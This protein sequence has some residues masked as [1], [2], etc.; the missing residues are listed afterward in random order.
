MTNP[1]NPVPLSPQPTVERVI[2]ALAPGDLNDLCDATDAAI[3]MG[4]GFGWVKLPARDVLERYWQ[5][6]VAMPARILVVARLDHV[7]CGAVQMVK[8]PANN[9]A[10]RF[11]LH[12]SGLF[13]APWARGQ[14][15]AK[16]LL[17]RAEEIAL[18]DGFGVI[19]LD[20]RETQVE[21]IRLYERAGYQLF[22][23]HPCYARVGNDII[24]GRYYTKTIDPHLQLK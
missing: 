23:T 19:N 3:E 18:D 4:G 22:G 5:G 2:S 13:L 15:L 17:H 1:S 12:L 6:V 20:V 8:P 7:I 24:P 14:G 16:M 10:Q 9:E 11:A 21:A